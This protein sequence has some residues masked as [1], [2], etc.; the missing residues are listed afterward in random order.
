MDN[1]TLKPDF[2]SGDFLSVEEFDIKEPFDPG[3]LGEFSCIYAWEIERAIIIPNG[4]NER[5]KFDIIPGK[6]MY[7]RFF[8]GFLYP[9][10]TFLGKIKFI[11]DAGEPDHHVKGHFIK[12]IGEDRVLLRGVIEDG[13]GAREFFY[14]H[15]EK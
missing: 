3:D 11:Q 12:I 14:I 8:T 15:L 5:I 13:R 1:K 2:L 4:Q 10:G 6:G 9:D 7:E